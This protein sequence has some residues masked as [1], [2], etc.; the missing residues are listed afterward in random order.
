MSGRNA[1]VIGAGVIGL[2]VARALAQQGHEV[3]VLEAAN[4]IGTQTSSRNSEVIHAGIG[5]APG[6]HKAR[7]CRQ[8]RDRLYAYCAAHGIAH[9]RVGKLIV[10][11]ETAEI[12]A[13]HAIG[14]R[15]LANG[16]DDLQWL[17]AAQARALEP[18]LHC[19]AALYSPSTG[20]VDSHALMLALQGDLEQA[21]GTVVLRT[22]VT[23][24]KLAHQIGQPH[25]I[26]TQDGTEIT[27][28]TVVNAAGHGAIPLAQ[29]THGLDACHIPTAW[30]VKGQYFTFSGRVPFRHLIYPVPQVA[31]WGIHLTLD[32][33]GQ[34][35]FGPDVQWTDRPDDWQLNPADAHRFHA[36]IRR[37]WPG[38]PADR[39]QP[40]Y[41]GVRP[42]I[43][44]PGHTGSD[45]GIQGPATHGVA[46]LVNLFG[47]E[48]PGLTSSLAIADA[49]VQQ[50]DA[51]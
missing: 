12:H 28:H 39:L 4:A 44:G 26:H 8:G 1:I 32:L 38:I 43:G 22:P 35:R 25:R 16:V 45:F 24:M 21:S 14:Q 15:A 20:I 36:A 40:G 18:E 19:E 30:F 13:L 5:Y 11:S 42:N 47:I 7:L 34:A 17:D 46:G 31:G 9:Q 37:Y 27:A 50:L 29:Q 48:S 51:G 23:A 6:S 10:A 2:A 49:V 41:A 33:A 3:L